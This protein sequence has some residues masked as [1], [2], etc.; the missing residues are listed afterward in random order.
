MDNK[1]ANLQAQGVWDVIKHGNNVEEC[2][3]RMPFDAIY[4]AV[5]EHVGREGLDK[6]IVGDATNNACGCGSG[7]GSKGADLEE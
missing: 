7:Q 1:D 3:D 6:E 5:P 2:K 4:N